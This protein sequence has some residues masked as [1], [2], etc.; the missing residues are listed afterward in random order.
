MDDDDLVEPLLDDNGEQFDGPV[1][2]EAS[3][4]DNDANDVPA[5][6]TEAQRANARL[7]AYPVKL[8]ARNGPHG[9]PREKLKALTKKFGDE[10]G[11]VSITKQGTRDVP[12]FRL[13]FT[14]RQVTEDSLDKFMRAGMIPCGTTKYAVLL[15]SKYASLLSYD[16][17]DMPLDAAGDPTAMGF[18][19]HDSD[20]V[21]LFR[22]L[23]T[24][25]ITWNRH[26]DTKLIISGPAQYD[27][28]NNLTSSAMVTWYPS[29]I[30]EEAEEASRKLPTLIKVP[31]TKRDVRHVQ[32]QTFLVGK[33]YNQLCHTCAKV[34]HNAGSVLCFRN[35][36]G[37]CYKPPLLQAP[38]GGDGGYGP[39][40][41]GPPGPGGG[42]GRGPGGQGQGR[43]VRARR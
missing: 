30:G 2:E 38:E 6:L 14:D 39:G 13:T 7:G 32:Q 27:G 19:A 36:N 31:D 20:P 35:P 18:P 16:V 22:D 25:H 43:N 10:R 24:D 23:S 17:R 29:E 40:G 4:N 9:Q 41:G 42:G 33:F 8:R 37:I 1:D 15:G 26:A 21:A 5:E 3:D 11:L 34:G 12:E 28:S